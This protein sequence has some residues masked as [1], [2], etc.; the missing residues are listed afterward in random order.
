[1]SGA[2]VQITRLLS[3]TEP[4]DVFLSCSVRVAQLVTAGAQLETNEAIGIRT[5]LVEARFTLPR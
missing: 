5:T 2:P 3:R 1:M 4:I